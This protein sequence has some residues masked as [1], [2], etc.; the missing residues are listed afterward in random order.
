MPQTVEIRGYGT[1]DFPDDWDD[2]QIRQTV[3]ER[4]A[5]RDRAK[6]TYGPVADVGLGAVRGFAGTLGSGAAGLADLFGAE[7]TGRSIRQA[8]DIQRPFGLQAP[9]STAANIGETLGGA[10]AFLG[11]T[12][13]A[14][15]AAPVVGAGAGLGALLAGATLGAGTGVEEQRQRRE[16]AE[17]EGRKIDERS[18]LLSALGG[19]AIGATEALPFGRLA[20]RTIAPLRR[21]LGPASEVGLEA[22]QKLVKPSLWKAVGAQA[23][24]EA[25]QEAFSQTAQSALEK[26]L[27]SPELDVT[28]GVGEAALGGAGHRCPARARP[29]RAGQGGRPEAVSSRTREWCYGDGSGT[30]C[31]ST[32]G[33]DER[34]E[35]TAKTDRTRTRR[36]LDCRDTRV[37]RTGRSTRTCP[38]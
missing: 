24:E 36:G 3:R 8:T 33:R 32:S 38:R 29:T 5:Q 30:G 35:R 10:G 23:A 28:A 11:A 17:L 26:Q 16:Q 22:A 18:E 7:E 9:G 15:L 6:T 37:G 2:D 12:G 1:Y 20:T 21:A 4:I 13:A 19:A 25:A 34:N 27:Y 14:A 31:H